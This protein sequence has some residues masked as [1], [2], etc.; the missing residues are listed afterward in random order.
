MFVCVGTW[1]FNPAKSM[2]V[3]DDPEWFFFCPRDY[4]Y[5]NSNRNNRAT[6]NGF[7]KVTGK[8]RLIKARATKAVIGKKRTV[9]FYK[10][11]NPGERTDWVMHEYN[12]VD[13]L[14]NQVLFL[15]YLPFLSCSSKQ[16]MI[17]LLLWN[18]AVLLLCREFCL[19]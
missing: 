13:T 7:W 5:S 3:S 9:V 6:K 4:K 11:R 15:L 1:I 18:W 14:P 16:Y 17:Y 2:V 8:E 12:S 10:G 19:E